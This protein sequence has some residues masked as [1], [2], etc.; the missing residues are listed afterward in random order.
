MSLLLIL[1]VIFL[2][3]LLLAIISYLRSGYDVKKNNKISNY[4]K[5]NRVIFN[6]SKH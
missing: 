5:N 6:S 1:F 3:S 4:L 2:V